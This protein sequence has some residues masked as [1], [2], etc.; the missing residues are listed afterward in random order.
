MERL[1][2]ARAICRRSYLQTFPRIGF[3]RCLGLRPGSVNMFPGWLFPFFG[4]HLRV[5]ISP[6]RHCLLFHFLGPRPR[7]VSN[8]LFRLDFFH[9][10]VLFGPWPGSVNT[11]FRGTYLLLFYP[12]RLCFYCMPHHLM[13]YLLLLRAAHLCFCATPHHLHSCKQQK[14]LWEP[15]LALASLL[16]QI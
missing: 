3:Q 6:D 4:F 12:V 1:I 8:L 13:S 5:R 10:F 14:R 16:F 9:L 15:I 11:F 2:V 7:G